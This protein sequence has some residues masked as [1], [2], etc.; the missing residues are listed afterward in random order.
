MPLPPPPGYRPRRQ[1][2]VDRRRIVLAAALFAFA[3]TLLLALAHRVALTPGEPLR[4]VHPRFWVAIIAMATFCGAW[5]ET[6]RQLS[7]TR[8]GDPG[9]REIR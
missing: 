1:L 3:S 4:P 9:R 5:V 7:L 8:R 2:R 6:M